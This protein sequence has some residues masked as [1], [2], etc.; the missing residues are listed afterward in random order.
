MSKSDWKDGLSLEE[1][2]LKT[3]TPETREQLEDLR[4]FKNVMVIG[5]DEPRD[6]PVRVYKRLREDAE[7]R[8]LEMLRMGE[9]NAKGYIASGPFEL[10]RIPTDL[11]RNL[12]PDFDE[13]SAKYET[14][15]FIGIRVFKQIAETKVES[16]NPYHNGFPGRPTIAH[17]V[18]A[19][20]DR[21]ASDGRLEANLAKQAVAMQQWAADNHPEVRTPTLKTLENSIRHRF[22]ELRKHHRT[23]RPSK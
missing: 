15:M 16:A 17:L 14:L 21:R 23:D 11:W 7:N 22:M 8:L 1:A 13:G 4:G 3:I 12:Q 19:E 6:A 18:L 9:L 5:I 10:A 20:L 2:L